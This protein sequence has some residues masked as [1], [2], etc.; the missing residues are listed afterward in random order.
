MPPITL[1]AKKDFSL[2]ILEQKQGVFLYNTKY[3]HARDNIHT[4]WEGKC[5]PGMVGVL[6]GVVMV[7]KNGKEQSM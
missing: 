2:Q 1:H 4:C 7:M 3:N 6:E 5:F